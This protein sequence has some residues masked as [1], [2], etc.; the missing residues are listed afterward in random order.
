MMVA[1]NTPTSIGYIR[2]ILPMITGTPIGSRKQF[3]AENVA[4]EIDV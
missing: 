1:R 3:A 4:P 2:S